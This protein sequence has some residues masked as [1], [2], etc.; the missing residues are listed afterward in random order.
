M[1]VIAREETRVELHHVPSLSPGGRKIIKQISRP[2]AHPGGRQ[3]GDIVE[4][5]KESKAGDW[6]H[7]SHIAALSLFAKYNDFVICN[8]VR[9]L[10]HV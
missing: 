8:P 10:L 3:R 9:L 6:F 5:S 2:R 7:Y 1:M 4:G